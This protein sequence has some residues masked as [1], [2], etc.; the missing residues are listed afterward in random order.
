MRSPLSEPRIQRTL[1]RY[2]GRKERVC[3]T[4]YTEEFCS[5]RLPTITQSIQTLF[6]DHQ[7]RIAA[8]AAASGV[9]GLSLD[10]DQMSASYLSKAVAALVKPKYLAEANAGSSPED[11]SQTWLPLFRGWQNKREQW[12]QTT[13]FTAHLQAAASPPLKMCFCPFSG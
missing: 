5:N 3:A 12:L 1:L 9:V 2:A 13:L 8:V 11:K 6:N 4:E 10:L 7:T